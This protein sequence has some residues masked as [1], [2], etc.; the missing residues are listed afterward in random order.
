[1]T[2]NVLQPYFSAGGNSTEQLLHDK[3]MNEETK[4][5]E[6][7]QPALNKGAVSS[8]FLFTPANLIE[9]LDKIGP[10]SAYGLATTALQHY[11]PESYDEE[12][13]CPIIEEVKLMNK[14][15]CEYWHD[16]IIKYHKEVGYI[17][18][19]GFDRDVVNEA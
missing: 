6:A 16:A 5:N 1:M 2:A 11:F 8:R 14:L 9:N 13:N 12:G 7:Q 15:G 3:I 10:W 19:N 18:P 17:A 4:V